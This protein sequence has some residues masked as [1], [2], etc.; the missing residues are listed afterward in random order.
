MAD[1]LPIQSGFSTYVESP[2]AP[3]QERYDTFCGWVVASQEIGA[4]PE[5]LE[6]GGAHQVAK[7][8]FGYAHIAEHFC[9][10][11][12][13][14]RGLIHQVLE[15]LIAHSDESEGVVIWKIPR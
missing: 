3:A 4:L 2:Y 7:G 6:P 15:W 10:H 13:T 14:A 11:R 5:P 9:V 12:L 1:T 8:A